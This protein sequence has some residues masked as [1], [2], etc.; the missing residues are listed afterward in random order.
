M[1][2]LESVVVDLVEDLLRD[3]SAKAPETGKHETHSSRTDSVGVRDTNASPHDEMRVLASSGRLLVAID[4]LFERETGLVVLHYVVRGDGT[5]IDMRGPEVCL[6]GLI[7]RVAAL[8]GL[9]AGVDE[10][11]LHLVGV[12]ALGGEEETRAENDTVGTQGQHASDLRTSG[13]TASG[14]DGRAIGEGCLDG[15]NKVKERRGVG[16]AVTT[17]FNTCQGRKYILARREPK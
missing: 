16:A 6:E 5:A 14:D 2:P 4:T 15:R 11:V 10:D 7:V 3:N 12:L 9:P 13:D 8:G 17:S 1:Q